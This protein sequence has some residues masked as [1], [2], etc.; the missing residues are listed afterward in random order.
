M[1]QLEVQALI[2]LFQP[3]I[4]LIIV[5]HKIWSHPSPAKQDEY[6]DEHDDNHDHG[7]YEDVDEDHVQDTE[8]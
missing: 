3:C 1:F 5:K 6:D 2:F 8:H 4:D 7:E